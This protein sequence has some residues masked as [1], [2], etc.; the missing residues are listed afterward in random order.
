MLKVVA[1]IHAVYFTFLL[2]LTFM[3]LSTISYIP[4]LYHLLALKTFFELGNL[5]VHFSSTIS[6]PCNGSKITIYEINRHKEV[7]DILYKLMHS[8]ST[9]V[10]FFLDLHPTKCLDCDTLAENP[11]T[12]S[13]WV[14]TKKTSTG[15]WGV[16]NHKELCHNYTTIRVECST[17]DGKKAETTGE[18]FDCEKDLGFVC[19]NIEQ[20]GTTCSDYKFRLKCS[21]KDKI[22]KDYY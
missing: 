16:A 19:R 12:W 15:S 11:G 10:Y 2:T 3:H 9:C 7:L 22:G 13:D 6:N 8:W 21:T 17:A 1:I 4:A 14:H 20:D 5:L 18:Y